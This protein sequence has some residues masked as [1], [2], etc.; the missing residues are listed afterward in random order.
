MKRL[1]LAAALLAVAA[2]STKKDEPIADTAAAG[3]APAPAATS[4][5]TDTGAMAGMKHDSAAMADSA[6]KA[7]SVKAAAPK[8]P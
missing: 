5:A 6:K 3:M 1:A 2:C 8:T 7:D 4:T